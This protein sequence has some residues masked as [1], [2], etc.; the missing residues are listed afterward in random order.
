MY[1]ERVNFEMFRLAHL[2]RSAAA[3]ARYDVETFDRA[4]RYVENGLPNETKRP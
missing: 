1:A 4:A 2:Q 3:P